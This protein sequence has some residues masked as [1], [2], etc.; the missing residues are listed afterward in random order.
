MKFV[1]KTTKS[2]NF[3]TLYLFVV[4]WHAQLIPLACGWLVLGKL[5]LLR[6]WGTV[7][8]RLG[9][10]GKKLEGKRKRKRK[11]SCGPKLTCAKKTNAVFWRDKVLQ[12]YHLFGGIIL[13]Q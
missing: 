13:R 7:R 8:N 11:A 5:V 3:C 2:C 1:V 9:F 10:Y 4:L 12:Y 6:S